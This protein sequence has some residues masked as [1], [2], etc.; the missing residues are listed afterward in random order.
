[1][2]RDQSQRVVKEVGDR[3]FVVVST[4]IY[5]ERG[6]YT[7]KLTVW[8]LVYSPLAM[9]KTCYVNNERPMH[10]IIS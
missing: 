2:T 10:D 4:S 3:W 6:F 8:P 9:N 7:Y 1:M 5:L